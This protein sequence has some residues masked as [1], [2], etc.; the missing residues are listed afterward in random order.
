MNTPSVSHRYQQPQEWRV[1]SLRE[2][3]VPANP[4]L[5]DTP[6][7]AVQYWHRHVATQPWLNPEVEC[8]VVLILNVRRRILGHQLVAIGTLDSV[9]THARE[10]FRTA[11]VANA[12]GIVLMH[13]HPS[14]EPEPSHADL[15]VTRD[16]HR[17]GQLLRIELLDHVIVAG[18]GHCSLKSL[19]HFH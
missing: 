6:E 2:C 10:V 13:N 14:G 4:L 16:L 15:H 5:C 12:H 3:P 8:L 17:A 11:I 7:I 1:V 18:Q 9:C 19:G